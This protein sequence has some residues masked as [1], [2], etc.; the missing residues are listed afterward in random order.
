MQ[1]SSS[2]HTVLSIVC[3]T[4]HLPG[5]GGIYQGISVVPHPLGANFNCKSPQV[6]TGDRIVCK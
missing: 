2:V 1:L 5:K 4:P 6:D 3:P